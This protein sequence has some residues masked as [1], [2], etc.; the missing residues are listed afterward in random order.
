M[1]PLK[2][3]VIGSLASGKLA[4]IATAST[5]AICGQIEV[6]KPFAPLNAISH[7]AFGDDALEQDELS[8]KYTA[9]GILLND[10]ACVSWAAIHAQCFGRAAREKNLALVFGGGALVSLLAYIVDYRLVP[11]RF[12]PGLEH[13]LSS[14]SLLVVY[15]A[16][17]VG[18]SIGSLLNARRER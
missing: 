10:A 1:K 11:K 18:L 6:G 15:I 13:R 2:D 5:A 12:T 16:L 9:T 4:S 17:A 8:L 7:I 14:R 3:I